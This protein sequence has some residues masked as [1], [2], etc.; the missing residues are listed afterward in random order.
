M[1]SIAGTFGSFAPRALR[2]DPRRLSIFYAC[3][4]AKHDF[5]YAACP[6]CDGAAGMA[7]VVHGEES[8]AADP[9]E[10]QLADPTFWQDGDADLALRA[11]ADLECHA[12]DFG[13]LGGQFR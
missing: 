2:T 12:T 10:A 7:F 3:D 8:A 9:G 4:S 1:Q 13:Q 5:D 6:E 11:F